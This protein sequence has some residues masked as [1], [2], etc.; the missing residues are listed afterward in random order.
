M[1]G[2]DR[3]GF[4]AFPTRAQARAAN[5]NRGVNPYSSFPGWDIDSVIVEN[6]KLPTESINRAPYI[7]KQP[8]TI[9]E[10]AFERTGAR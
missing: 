1:P 6:G 9:T 10:M 8:D 2:Y 3:V 5:V 4:I 7:E